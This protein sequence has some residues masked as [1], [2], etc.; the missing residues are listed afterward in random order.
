M[1]LFAIS[2]GKCCSFCA[3]SLDVPPQIWNRVYRIPSKYTPEIERHFFPNCYKVQTTVI[4]QLKDS[5]KSI[6][7]VHMIK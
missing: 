3:C 2:V 7:T 1:F 5:V 4:Q 6:N